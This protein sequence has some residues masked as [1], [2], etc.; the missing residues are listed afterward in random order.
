[1]TLQGDG[2]VGI[3]TNSPQSA[4]QVD[5][6][7]TS[8]EAGVSDGE[9]LLEDSAAIGNNAGIRTNT[10]GDL[11]LR[12]HSTP[13]DIEFETGNPESTRMVILQDGRVGIGR[14]PAA[15]ALE[16]EGEASKTTGG[17]WLVNSDRRIK[18]EI[19]TIEHALDAIDKVRLVSF[20]YTDNYRKDHE[21]I[22][23]HRYINVIAQEFAEVFPDHVKG[24]GE[25]LPDGSE[26]LQVDAWPLTIYSAAAVQ[27][28]HKQVEA[29]D[30]EI[31]DLTARLE[32]MEAMM[33]TL[34]D[35]NQGAK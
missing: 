25:Y 16:V 28:L 12:A 24:S 20:E 27:E 34:I 7:I 2:N 33:N 23:S 31:A 18:K 35:S 22:D 21:G 14:T 15:N 30:A 10:D 11:I 3:G 29:K 8:G 5:G 17:L 32:R 9:I 6:V 19:R 13:G 26:I 1:M 4:L